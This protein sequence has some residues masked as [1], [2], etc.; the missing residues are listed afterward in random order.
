MRN[1]APPALLPHG[2]Q[3]LHRSGSNPIDPPAS[4]LLAHDGLPKSS[5]LHPPPANSSAGGLQ[6]GSEGSCWLIFLRSCRE[7]TAI[8]LFFKRFF[9]QLQPNGSGTRGILWR[10]EL[11]FALEI[12]LLR[13]NPCL[14]GQ[15]SSFRCNPIC[16]LLENFAA[17]LEMILICKLLETFK[18]LNIKFYL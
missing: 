6:I 5:A 8:L 18:R 1:G 4:R 7:S 13:I 2:S 3:C 12:S 16:S 17:R 14:S 11:A 15:I 9:L 10:R